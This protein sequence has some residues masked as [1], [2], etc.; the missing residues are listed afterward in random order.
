MKMT[1][2]QPWDVR[3]QS[4]GVIEIGR[5]RSVDSGDGAETAE[6]DEV[7]AKEVAQSSSVL[8]AFGTSLSTTTQAP[9]LG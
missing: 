9:A 7:E 6:S 5:P 2:I 4:I 1:G 8:A 3:R